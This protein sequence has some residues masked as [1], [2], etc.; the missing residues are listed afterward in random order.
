M[1]LH[2]ESDSAGHLLAAATNAYTATELAERDLVLVDTASS[3]AEA[4]RRL[5]E[6]RTDVAPLSGE[7]ITHAVSRDSLALAGGGRV[8]EVATPLG[9]GDLVTATT[10]LVSVLQRLRD[11]AALFVL[12]H[13]R[14]SGIIT[15]SDLQRPSVAICALTL[16]LGVESGLNDLIRDLAGNDGLAYLP[17]GERRADVEKVHAQRREA[18]ADID[19]VYALGFPERLEIAARCPQIRNALGLSAG[20]LDGHRVKLGDLRNSLAHGSDLLVY[21]PDAD[22]ALDALLRAHA[23][24]VKVVERCRRVASE[25]EA[26]VEVETRAGAEAVSVAV[27]DSVPEQLRAWAGESGIIVVPATKAARRAIEQRVSPKS[28]RQAAL[29]KGETSEQFDAIAVFGLDDRAVDGMA[30][31]ANTEV[32]FELTD[33]AK[34][35]WL[36]PPP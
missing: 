17:A 9:T 21:E 32:V 15:R 6:H 2:V 3:V 18:N 10:P 14:V 22:L 5:D 35:R 1:T 23:L 16:I 12:D 29:S 13:D 28:T 19:L 7:R 36:P 11:R 31:R 4:L 24:A 30:G 34:L 33:T 20:V 25:Q 27:G 26:R 8:A